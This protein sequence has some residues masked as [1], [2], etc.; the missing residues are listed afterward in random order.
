MSDKDCYARILEEKFDYTNTYYDREPRLDFRERHPDQAETYDFILSAD[1]IE[2]I[3]PPVERALGEVHSLL[4]PQ[5]F[6]A[7]TVYCSPTDRLREHFPELFDYRVVPLAGRNVLVNRR[8]D[9]TLEVRDDLIFHGGEG[10]TLEMREFGISALDAKLR[11]AGFREIGF[12]KSNVPEWGILFDH[13]TSQPLIGRKQPYIL[14]RCA[15]CQ[16]FGAWDKATREALET[17]ERN[18]RL[19]KQIQLARQSRWLRLGRKMGVGPQFE[20]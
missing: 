1:V 12:L 8:R 20:E 4:K 16:L 2:H 11:G 9:R 3:A 17:H 15:Q 7:V 19:A 5:G 14:D 10:E 13:D 6:F 18:E